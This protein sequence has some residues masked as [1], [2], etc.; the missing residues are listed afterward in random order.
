MRLQMHPGKQPSRLINLEDLGSN[1]AGEREEHKRQ[2]MNETDL[3]D[4]SEGEHDS[5]MGGKGNLK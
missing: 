2:N 5:K 4:E 3:L 1:A